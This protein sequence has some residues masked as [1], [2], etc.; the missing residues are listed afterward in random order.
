MSE[1]D[2]S[3][4]LV[5]QPWVMVRMNDGRVIELSLLDTFRRAREIACLLG[6]V[7]TQV[8]ALTRLLL[9]ILHRAV[10]GPADVDAWERLWADG[11]PVGTVETYLDRHRDRFDLL[12]PVTPFFQ[13]AGL[14]T[15]KGE[16]SELSKLIADVPNGRP[17]FSTRVGAPLRLSLAEAARWVV[18]CQAFD[19]SGI[20]SGAVGDDR[21]T[22]GKGY[23][24]GQG[25]SG[26]LGGMLVEGHN[27][28]E[29]LLLNLIAADFEPADGARDDLPVWE[30]VAP[31]A[32]EEVPGGRAPAGPLELFTWQSRRIRLAVAA[33]E[34]TGVLVC[35]GD[36]L[37]P[38]NLFAVEPHTAWRRSKA[39]QT[40]LK[41]STPVYMPLEHDPSRAIWRG[42]QAMLP[43]AAVSTSGAE[44]AARLSP[45][46]I[47]WVGHLR[48]EDALPADFTVGLHSTGVVYGSQNS[49]V[50]EIVEDRMSL[51]AV[52]LAQGAADLTEVVVS[53]VAAAED[54]A[55][56]LGALAAN[57]VEAGGG[58]HAGPRSRAIESA[59]D[60]LDP[61]FR[62]WVRELGPASD[63]TTCQQHWHE[64]AD[65][66][67]RRLGLELV[68][69]APK[70][71]WA[72]RVRTGRPVSAVHADEWF[73]SALRK[74]LPMSHLPDRMTTREAMTTPTPEKSIQDS[75]PLRGIV[76]DRAGSLQDAY[77]RKVSAG[78]AA[79]ARLRRGAGKSPGSVVDIL[80]HTLH[81]VFACG[82][83]DDEPTRDEIAAHHCLTMFAL[84]QQSQAQRMH[85]PGI[86]L[87][88]AIRRLVPTD[89]RPDNPVTRRFAML[90]T[91][92]SLDELVH[93]LRGVV[94]LLR[95]AG[96][97]LDYGW[98]AQDLSNWQRGGD[99]RTRVILA[100]G[101]AFHFAT[102]PATAATPVIEQA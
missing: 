17:F 10:D 101:R 87:G 58:E 22:G 93:H 48:W 4:D 2:P 95:G 34:V 99:P 29:T 5:D 63:P 62:A 24:I 45:Q 59:Y 16:V 72:G 32:A 76:A 68:A 100:W 49:V 41:S 40:K 97:P 64:T 7:P 56:A 77:L 65:R 11:F 60:E 53:C 18:H 94:Q 3:F 81:P 42:L 9:A 79:L 31:G 55:K 12:H 47:R 30:R 1:P 28:R 37:T 44:P 13:V 36:K 61:L 83:R 91:A 8:F 102:G 73:D 38:Q 98:L 19:I 26:H 88:T 74:A 21:V 57:L 96:T 50:D 23:P 6:D 66:A 67:V 85:R 20:K 52:L 92:D 71:S 84:H 15:S 80:E 33:D 75:G 86:R 27:L 78:V 25:W 43:T 90:S 70:V 69:Q 39:Q 46:V 51:A 82:S 54:A 14:R 35:N 89:S